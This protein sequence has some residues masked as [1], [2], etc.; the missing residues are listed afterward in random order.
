MAISCSRRVDDLARLVAILSLAGGLARAAEPADALKTAFRDDFLIGVA[1]NQRQ[2]T[3][4]DAQG[5]ALVK[6]QFNSISPENVLKWESVHPRP[7]AEGY[8]F[9]AADRYV[10]FGEKNGMHIVGHT[11]V[12]HS[13]TPRWV[14]RGDDGQPITRDA[15][16]E[17]MRDHIH[18]VVGRY[19][20]RIQ[21]WDVVNEA[22]NE[23]GSL[24]RSPWFEIIGEDYI[25]KA[26]EY[27]HEADPEAELRYN[28][29][30]IENEPKRKGAIA[31]VKKLQAAHIPIG[32]LG[33]QTHATLNWPSAELLD[34]ALTDFAELGLP[35]SITELDVNAAQGGQRRQSA[36]VAANAQAGGGGVV[37]QANQKLAE[38]YATLFRVFLKHREHIKLVTFWGVTD[39]DSWRRFGTPL[40]FDGSWQPKP[41]F[42]AVIA[43]ALREPAESE[44]PPATAS[45]AADRPRGGPPGAG[46]GAA[47]LP[48][49]VKAERNIPYVEHGHPN[50]VLDLYLPEA[51]PDEPLPLVI[52]IHGGAWLGGDQANPPVLY[53]LAKGFAVAS[54]QYRM[55]SQAT[56]PAQAH[57]CKAAVRFLRAQARQYHL[58]ADR[59]GVGGESAGG[60]LAAFVGASGDVAEME[61]DLG[62]GGTSSRVQAVVDWFGPTDLTLMGAQAGPGSMI[63]HDAANSPESLLVGGPIQDMRDVARTANPLTYVD[64]KDPPFLIMHGDADRLVPLAQSAILAKALVDAG[65]EVTMQTIPGAGHGGPQFHSPASRRLVE[66]FF[67]RHLQ[68]GG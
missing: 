22:L 56:W 45:P 52:W 62:A 42:A 36:D 38:Q 25:A 34:A 19:K 32:G 20:G 53:L 41:A 51:A 48:P 17:R 35:I 9:S 33:S 10:E 5:A 15:L 46:F 8:D 67:S 26:F 21:A 61:G 68:P 30:S 37:D 29:Y 50:Q 59:F 3:E 28:D 39:R 43:E 1:L 54:I 47:A 55:S 23:D 64:A 65:V 18:T 7:G 57:D 13:Q 2:F 66:E 12:W 4:Q 60:H 14:F 11:L 49:G 40:L 24:R 27:A 16:L 44:S 6:R 58:D 63:Q 31:L